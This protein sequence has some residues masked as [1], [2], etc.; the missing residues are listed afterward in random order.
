MDSSENAVTAQTVFDQKISQAAAAAT[1]S[2]C[3]LLEAIHH[4]AG[5]RDVESFRFSCLSNLSCIEIG[6]SD[7]AWFTLEL[8]MQLDQE[9]VQK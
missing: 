1:L 8:F 9:G 2:Q 7:F 4:T 5:Q 3:L 6:C